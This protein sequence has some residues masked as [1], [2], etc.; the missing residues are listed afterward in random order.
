MNTRDGFTRL[1]DTWLAEE[2][3]QSTPD[4]LDQ[5]LERTSKTGQRPAWLSPGR[6]LPVD[7]TINPRAYSLPPAARYALIAALLLIVAVAALVLFAG[8]QR[9]RVPAP[10]GPAAN[11]R[12]YFDVDGAIVTTNA[13]GSG[14]QT[15]NV[16]V[17]AASAP[18]MSPDGTKFMFISV[19]PTTVA[20]GSVFVAD[21][22]GSHPR[23]ISG[24]LALDIDP[25]FN[26]TWSPDGSQVAFS[27][28]EGGHNQLFVAN[29][30]GSGV[31]S[32]GDD[33]S[34]ARTNP[35][36]SPSGEWIAFESWQE[37]L[38]ADPGIEGFIAV[39][40]PDGTGER[41]LAT[42]P[43]SGEGFRGFQL[44]APDTTNR[45]A[46]STG[47]TTKPEGDAIAVMAVDSGIETILSDVPGTLEHRPAWSPD[48]SRIA[49]H[50]G[51][52]IAVANADGSGRIV[53]GDTL[54]GPFGWSP[55]G[56]QVFG[57]SL[58]GL[59]IKAIDV[60]GK[61]PTIVIPF[62]GTEAGVFSWQRA[63]P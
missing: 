20:G 55:D 24:A 3:V 45:I 42:S 44:W 17:P 60:A 50:Q 48:G 39:I 23:K 31:R 30:D 29:A 11:G 38:W 19:D 15:I 35:E 1:L 4:Y 58:D 7:T 41:R 33:K 47:T 2:G 36:W 56:T 52:S 61:R 57:R 63:A 26:P 53:L 21:A 14:R 9:H 27:A 32:L 43:G 25:M 34:F 54:S 13:D 18:Y 16:G 28:F 46:Y 6:W 22:D 59:Q 5:A 62:N 37:S 40:H 10:F 8:S 49:F 51:D 12:I